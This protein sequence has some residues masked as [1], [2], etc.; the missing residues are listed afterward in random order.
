MSWGFKFIPCDFLLYLQR[1]QAFISIPVKR[2]VITIIS[3]KFSDFR[4][5]SRVSKNSP[6]DQELG[7]VQKKK[8]YRY[9]KHNIAVSNLWIRNIKAYHMYTGLTMQSTLT[10]YLCILKLLI[11]EFSSMIFATSQ[12]L[13]PFWTSNRCSSHDQLWCHKTWW[14]TLAKWCMFINFVYL[15]Y[16]VS[17]TL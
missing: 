2:K 14:T 10:T 6:Q 11:V 17:A 12:T 1:I 13:P 4:L 7:T 16:P 8:F 5:S 3:Y 9:W 15:I